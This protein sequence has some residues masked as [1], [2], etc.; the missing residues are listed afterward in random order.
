[1]LTRVKQTIHTETCNVACTDLLI[2]PDHTPKIRSVL[3][4]M[5]RH[6]RAKLSLI[7]HGM[8]VTVLSLLCLCK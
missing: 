2:N 8:F 3:V 6:S 5:N 4:G 1:M 7:T